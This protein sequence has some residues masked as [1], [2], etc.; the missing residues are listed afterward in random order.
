MKRV[1]TA[2]SE[3]QHRNRHPQ[4]AHSTLFIVESFGRI[5]L[6]CLPG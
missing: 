6:R 1:A 2:D 5:A 4:R 3:T